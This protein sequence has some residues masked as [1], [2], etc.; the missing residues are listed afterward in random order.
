MTRLP[1]AA[2]AAFIGL[3]WAAANH[4]VGLQA[5]GSETREFR[6]LGHTL[7]TLEA[8][9]S[10]WR[11]PFKGQPS[12]LGLAL[13][14]GPLVD[15]RRKDDCRVRFAVNPLPLARYRDAFAPSHAKADPT[16]A[17]LPLDLLLTPREKLPPLNPQSPGLRTLAP[18][19]AQRRRLVGDTGRL[20]HRLSRTLNND[21]P[22]V[23]P[24]VHDQDTAI[25]GD[26]LTPWPPLQAAPLARRPTLE[27]FV[28]AP[29]VRYADVI[30]IQRATPLT[31]E[32]GVSVPNALLAQARVS[33]LRVTLHASADF[34][35]ALAPPAQSPPDVPLLAALPGAGAVFAPRLLG[36][37]GAQRDRDASADERQQDAGL[38]PVTARRGN[39]TWGHGRLQCPTVW[40]HTCVEGAAESTPHACWARADDPQPRHQSSSHQAAV[41]ALACPWLPDSLQVLAAA[42]ARCRNGL[43]QRLATPGLATCAPRCAWCLKKIVPDSG[44]APSGHVLAAVATVLL[45]PVLD[46]RAAMLKSVFRFG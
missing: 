37:F 5:A 38:A 12:A 16:D 6:V 9:G 23:R 15:A 28:R 1:T 31:T 39:T 46:I 22:Q 4:D 44:Q 34:D 21:F 14:H 43:S 26:V 24:W 41:R 7:A 36:A 27:R 45:R 13:H 40:R 3:D 19:V 17:A 32:E 18:L 20:T 29:H 33:Q 35:H 30:A 10:P 2:F 42:H 11:P 8:W 25:F